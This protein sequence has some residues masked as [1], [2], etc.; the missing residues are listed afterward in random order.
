VCYIAPAKKRTPKAQQ[1]GFK[2][3][4]SVPL[5]TASS[6]MQS[7]LNGAKDV[8]QSRPSGILNNSGFDISGPQNAVI[9]P[10]I[11][12]PLAMKIEEANL[13]PNVKMKRRRYSDC[14]YE[15]GGSILKEAHSIKFILEIKKPSKRSLRLDQSSESVNYESDKAIDTEVSQSKIQV[16]KF[17]GSKAKMMTQA[18]GSQFVKKNGTLQQKHPLPTTSKTQD[19]IYGFRK[20][21]NVEWMG[22]LNLHSPYFETGTKRQLTQL[23]DVKPSNIDKK[24]E[25]QHEFGPPS[26]SN[27]WLPQESARSVRDSSKFKTVG[28]LSV[29]A[30]K[31]A[32]FILEDR[33]PNQG[34]KNSRKGAKAVT[35]QSIR[36]GFMLDHQQ[37][38][39][40]T[41][42][43]PI[44]ATKRSLTQVNRFKFDADRDLDGQDYTGF[45]AEMLVEEV[46]ETPAIIRKVESSVEMEATPTSILRND[47]LIKIDGPD[48]NSFK[49]N[50]DGHGHRDHNFQYSDSSENSVKQANQKVIDIGQIQEKLLVVEVTE[51]RETETPGFPTFGKLTKKDTNGKSSSDHDSEEERDTSPNFSNNPNSMAKGFSLAQVVA[52]ANQ[53]LSQFKRKATQRMTFLAGGMQT[54]AG[55]NAG[56]LRFLGAQRSQERLKTFLVRGALSPNQAFQSYLKEEE[57]FSGTLDLSKRRPSACLEVPE[58]PNKLQKSAM[59]NHAEA[60]KASVEE[61]SQGVAT[62]LDQQA[63]VWTVIPNNKTSHTSSPPSK[64]SSIQKLPKFFIPE[65]VVHLNSNGKKSSIKPFAN[66]QKDSLPR[67][68]VNSSE[69]Q[70]TASTA[71]YIGNYTCCSPTHVSSKEGSKE[72]KSTSIQ[73]ASEPEPKKKVMRIKSIKDFFTTRVSVGHLASPREGLPV[74]TQQAM[75]YLSKLRLSDSL[76]K[77]VKKGNRTTRL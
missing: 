42:K 29:S 30:V 4:K 20:K 11:I 26:R 51:G 7:S 23:S 28:N 57:K 25:Y 14:L 69:N 74:K 52:S 38:H 32:D 27:A 64:G 73:K 3:L 19:A 68:A 18:Q 34:S 71:E 60:S 13:E 39:T 70:Q 75:P 49:G 54:N 53:Q 15:F 5:L 17:D 2:A 45:P 63:Q 10:N 43:M 36:V 48:A 67:I 22:E 46:P 31:N 24:Y 6:P 56:A 12:T 77:E 47:P 76:L 65:E 61:S 55:A 16:C 1:S 72:Q 44:A 9:A 58:Q 62:K 21:N 59:Q 35:T 33:D 66:F 40:D 41:V 50:L 8:H 37:N